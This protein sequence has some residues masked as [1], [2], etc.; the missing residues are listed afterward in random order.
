MRNGGY[1]LL[2]FYGHGAHDEDGG[3]LL[4]ADEFGRGALVR[5]SALGNV[6]RNTD[7]R[8]VLLGACQSATVNPLRAQWAPA[9]RLGEEPDPPDQTGRIWQGT[10]AA[11]VKAG[12]PL[13]V[14]MQVSMRVDAAQAF[15]RQFALSLA[16]GKPVTAAV[17]DARLP[18]LRADRGESWFIPA[19]YGRPKDGQR[20]F[21]VSRPLPAQN[22]DVRATMKATR[23]Q[24]AQL[25]R[26]IGSVG[27]LGQ[28]T[29]IA[30]LRAARQAFADARFDL[31]QHT[32]GGYT[33]VT[34]PL[35]G[36]PSNPIFV[37]RGDEL[38]AVGQALK[39]GSSGGDLGCG[40]HW[41]E[42]AGHGDGPPPKLAFS[43]R[44]PLARLSGRTGTGH[45]AGTHGRLLWA[46]RSGSGAARGEGGHR[47]HRAGPP[48]GPLSA[49]L[50]QCRG[51]MGRRPRAPLCARL[52]LPANVQTLLTTRE[53]PEQAMWTTIEVRPLAHVEHGQPLLRPRQPYPGQGGRPAGPGRDRPHADVAGRASAGPGPADSL[54]QAAGAAARL[55]RPAAATAQGRS[56]RLRRQ[57]PRPDH[58][59][60][61][62]L[63]PP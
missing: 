22:A 37:G 53:D 8:L 40:R 32:P 44:R 54:S 21:D 30:Q 27:V 36:V 1:H 52:S 29:E 4:F 49:D 6:L 46:G 62:A 15:L 13:A 41:Q 20:L 34:S 58:R 9:P 60:A 5:A 55:G 17:A 31:A 50:G 26:A 23:D 2:I 47:A 56:R 7:V 12:V 16:A 43:R 57:L 39:D 28:A 14:G 38:I 51:R 63:C 10:A 24:I 42:R 59:P 35:Y 3:Q 45:A 18:I 25:E 11:L 33:Q 48:R 61:A 19:L